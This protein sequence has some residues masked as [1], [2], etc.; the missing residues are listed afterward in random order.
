MCC[1]NVFSGSALTAACDG[2]LSAWYVAVRTMRRMSCLMDQPS[3]T[4]RSAR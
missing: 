3:L 4:N 1:H 2:V